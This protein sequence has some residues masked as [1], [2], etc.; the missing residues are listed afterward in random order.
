MTNY[1]DLI[2]WQ[3]ISQEQVLKEYK[4]NKQMFEEEL[5][6]HN[7]IEYLKVAGSSRGFLRICD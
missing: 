2:T 6:V 1:F 7:F 4:A 5:G 3:K